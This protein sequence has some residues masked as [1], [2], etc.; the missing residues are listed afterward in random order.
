MPSTFLHVDGRDLMPLPLVQR[1]EAKESPVRY[2]THV[3]GGGPAFFRNACKLGLEGIVSKLAAS[4]YRSGHGADWLKTKCTARQELVIGGW[5]PSITG[6]RDFG[7]LLVGYYD[8]GKL[9]YAGK[10]GTGFDTPTRRQLV[11]RL[12]QLWRERS[13]FVEVPRPDARD[14]RW[15]EP[16][17]VAEVEFTTWTRDG[18]VRHP[19]FKGLREDTAP[20]SVTIEK[21]RAAGARDG[22]R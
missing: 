18:R 19:S 4:S 20:K 6:P 16:K 8:G 13:P 14:A 10:V 12:Q 22:R 3:V 5:S 7:A 2:S 1:K 11:T 21:P 15:L 9:I 17:L